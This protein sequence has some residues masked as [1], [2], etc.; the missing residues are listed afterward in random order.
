MIVKYMKYKVIYYLMFLKIL[1]TNV[2]VQNIY[3]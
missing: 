1:L 3:T 2:C